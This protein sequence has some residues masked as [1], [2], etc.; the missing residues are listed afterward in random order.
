[1]F[2][3]TPKELW[4]QGQGSNDM[5][6]ILTGHGSEIPDEGRTLKRQW[7]DLNLLSEDLVHVGRNQFLLMRIAKTSATHMK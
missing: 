1:M 5:D 4:Y 2:L 7:R 3:L 6:K